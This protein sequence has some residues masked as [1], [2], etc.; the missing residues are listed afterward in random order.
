MCSQH[1]VPIVQ[2]LSGSGVLVQWE[3]VPNGHYMLECCQQN[4]G[5]WVVVG[6]GPVQGLSHVVEGLDPGEKYI[7]K[8]NSGPPSTPILIE[9]QAGSSSWQQE[10][11]RRRYVE[12][13]ELGHGRFS[14]VKRAR[15]R[16]TAQEVAVKQVVHKKQVPEVTQAEYTLMARL[17]HVN[18]VRALALFDSAPQPGMDSIVMEL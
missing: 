11:F 15:D 8:V 4:S 7:F 6:G 3:G 13:E 10:Q 16:G 14:V 18:V 2:L 12:L 17:Q 5:S 1:G 9:S